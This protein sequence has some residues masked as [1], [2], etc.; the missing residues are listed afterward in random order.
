MHTRIEVGASKEEEH[1]FL[2]GGEGPV[3]QL[4]GKKR[5]P[6]PTPSQ[7]SKSVFLPT[8][9]C[10]IALKKQQLW[11]LTVYSCDKSH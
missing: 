4:S 6:E 3:G 11:K 7:P 10:Q 1:M 8:H 2:A 5:K 9:I